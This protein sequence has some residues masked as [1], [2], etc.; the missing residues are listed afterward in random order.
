ATRGLD[1]TTALRPRRGPA[2][3]VRVDGEQVVVALPGRT[4]TLPAVAEPALRRLLDGPATPVELTVG[5]LD[6]EGALVLARRMLREGVVV[7]A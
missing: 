4:V 6:L 2:A 1:A 3:P 5:G 7:P